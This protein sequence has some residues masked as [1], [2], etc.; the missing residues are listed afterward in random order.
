M[1]KAVSRSFASMAD[2]VIARSCST[3]TLGN[4]VAD[5]KRIA[6][7]LRM[8][9]SSGNERRNA[10]AAL[11]RTMQNEGI[12][13]SDIGN[14]IEH[15]GGKY[16][17]DELQEYGQALRAEGVE[18]GIKIGASRASN[19]NGHLALPKP[20]EMAAYCHDRSSRLKDDKQRD[21]VNDMLVITRRG[22]SLSP[23]RLGYL[24]SIYIQIGGR[25]GRL[26]FCD[27]Q[28]NPCFHAGRAGRPSRYRE[29]HHTAG[30]AWSRH[31]GRGAWAPRRQP[32]PNRA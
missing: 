18:A 19:G 21:F 6:K 8:L 27:R 16:T 1:L 9:G 30:A 4:A 28:W 10:F 7:L 5:L 20:S 22:A 2:I 26:R 14:A 13:W 15:D 3:S 31:R 24:A 17:E 23:G 11:E 32:R 12:S 29:Q 25:V